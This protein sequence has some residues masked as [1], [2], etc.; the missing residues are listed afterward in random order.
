VDALHAQGAQ[1]VGAGLG[2]GVGDVGVEAR[3]HDADVQVA[4]VQFEGLPLI[5]V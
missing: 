4:A 3:L 1:L 5:G 2:Q